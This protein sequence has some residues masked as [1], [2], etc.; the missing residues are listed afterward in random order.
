MHRKVKELSCG[1]KRILLLALLPRT[2]RT[3]IIAGRFYNREISINNTCLVFWRYLRPAS[4]FANF[5]VASEQVPGISTFTYHWLYI[6][7]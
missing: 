6:N 4:R 7:S 5:L 1:E 3:D 2:V